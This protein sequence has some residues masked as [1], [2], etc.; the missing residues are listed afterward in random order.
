MRQY[1]P[2]R[3]VPVIFGAS[4]AA[5]ICGMS[6]YATPAHVFLS[7][8]HPREAKADTDAQ[9]F[10]KAIEPAVLARYSETTH[11]VIRAPVPAFFHPVHR[12]LSAT[13]DG[14]VMSILGDPGG[15]DPP[16]PFHEEAL[17]PIDSKSTG[18]RAQSSW[19]EEGTDEVPM[20]VL[21]QAQQQMFVMGAEHQ[22]T[23][24][25]V[26]SSRSIR[27]YPIE[28]NQDLCDGIVAAARE[29]SERIVLNDPP[30]P[31]WTH[32][33][34][35]EINKALFGINEVLRKE[36]SQEFLVAREAYRQALEA[37]KEAVK[38][39]EAAKG[40]MEWLMG[41]AAFLELGD[42]KEMV[43]SI[44]KRKEYVVKACE[45]VSMRERKIPK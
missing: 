37:E 4:D 1:D 44:V 34:A 15:Q 22:E 9:W 42:G 35:R 2:D 24:T 39:K 6:D 17:F 32:P 7:Q 26:L 3:E 18:F 40:Q 33:R 36:A 45:Y 8:T 10:G 41:D 12:F 14:M 43:R 21:F 25:L 5:A 38:A 13:P 27:I 19:G 30:E 20:D 11:N 16:M 29:L 28:R 31:N 23:V